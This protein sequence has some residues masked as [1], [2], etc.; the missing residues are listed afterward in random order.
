MCIALYTRCFQSICEKTFTGDLGGIRTHD[1]LLAS[2]DSL[3]SRPPSLPDDDW[4]A[5]IPYSSRFPDYVYH[6]MQELTNIQL[7][8]SRHGKNPCDGQGKSQKMQH[9]GPSSLTAMFTSIMQSMY[10][11]CKGKLS[12]GSFTESGECNHSR[13]SFYLIRKGEI[14]R[15]RPKR[16]GAATLPGTRKLRAVVGLAPMNLNARR[17]SC[18]CDS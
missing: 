11:F 10:N 12:K 14:Q 7:F 15:N 8:G 6:P 17:L 18:F 4:P 1:L 9:Q 3:T 2:A 16:T 13:R 5:R